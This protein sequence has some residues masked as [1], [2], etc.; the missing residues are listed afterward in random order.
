MK[1]K[2]DNG[3]ETNMKKKLIVPIICIALIVGFLSGCTTETPP[4]ETPTNEE[5]K[6]DFTYTILGLTVTFT[7]ASEDTDG[8]ITEWLWDFGDIETSTEQNP[9]HIYAEDNTTYSVTLTVTDDDGDT[10]SVTKTITIG[11]PNNPPVALFTYEVND[12]T[13]TATFTDEST[14][15]D[16][17]TLTYSWDFGDNETSTEQ[18]PAH[19]Y[20]I[21][22]SYTVVLTVDDGEDPDTHTEDIKVGKTPPTAE[23][24]ALVN[25]T[26][27]LMVYFQEMSLD[28]SIVSWHW[29]FGDGTT[30]TVYTVSTIHP[31]QAEGTYTVTLTVTN[32]DGLTASTSQEVVIDLT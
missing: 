11:T 10:D 26:F 8:D 23:F 25:E 13:K 12:T 32:E 9:E 1:Y 29:D 24:I 17:D 21:N 14:D 22:G 30:E 16:N 31:Y 28:E 27:E 7:D 18:N 6:A 4:D 19:T 2:K 5:P 20:A 3:E 15:A